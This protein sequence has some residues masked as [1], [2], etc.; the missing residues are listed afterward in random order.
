M[1]PLDWILKFAGFAFE[2]GVPIAREVITAFTDD[3]PELGEPPPEASEDQLW[4]DFLRK[5]AERY[6]DR[7]PPAVESGTQAWI[8]VN[9]EQRVMASIDTPVCPICGR[10]YDP[11][12]QVPDGEDVYE[13]D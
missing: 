4:T 1:N 13:P 9:C 3:N 5:V 8:C 10:A 2:H 6:P 7:A 12:D 11:T